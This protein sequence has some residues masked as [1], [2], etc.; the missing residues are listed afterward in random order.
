MVIG[1]S[2]VQFV[3]SWVWLQTEL[4]DT[5]SCCLFIINV[6]IF[7]KIIAFFFGERT[8]NTKCSKWE[9]ISPAKTL[10]NVTNSSILENPQFGRV[11]VVVAMVILT[12]SVIGGFSWVHLIWLAN[13][14]VRLQVLITLSYYNPTQWLVKSKAANA[15]I[16]FEEIVMVMIIIIITIMILKL[17]CTF[18]YSQIISY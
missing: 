14:T 10:S 1:L 8:F 9:K 6:R 16:K 17:I 4:D 12:T 5:K 11:S 13:V 2:G 7:A 18:C 3:Y 15:P